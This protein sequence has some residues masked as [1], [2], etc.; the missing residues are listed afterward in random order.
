PRFRGREVGFCGSAVCG[1]SMLYR[2]EGCCEV[3]V[4]ERIRGANGS[5]IPDESVGS[6]VDADEGGV[7]E[8]PDG[9]NPGVRSE[10]SALE[11]RRFGCPPSCNRMVGEGNGVGRLDQCSI[12]WVSWAM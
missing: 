11:A 2:L 6:A 1:W 5:G 8:R 3:F 10:K 12:A 9:Q 4:R 7:G